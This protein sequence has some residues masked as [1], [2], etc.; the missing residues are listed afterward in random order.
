MPVCHLSQICAIC[1]PYP[2][3]V[4]SGFQ[5]RRSTISSSSSIHPDQSH[6]VLANDP[7]GYPA[8]GQPYAYDHPVSPDPTGYQP[9][10]AQPVQPAMYN[11]PYEST[12]RPSS[13]HP[14]YARQARR[15]LPP[16]SSG[17]APVPASSGF[18]PIAQQNTGYYPP[19]S[20]TPAPVHHAPPPTPGLGSHPS[21]YITR[22]PPVNP[23]PTPA[24]SNFSFASQ[25]YPAPSGFTP[26]SAY[27]HIP[28]P[29]P[30][31]GYQYP[32]PVPQQHLQY[33]PPQLPP[34]NTN[35]HHHPLPHPPTP[36]SVP[37]PTQTANHNA[38]YDHSVY[39]NVPPPPP[40][41]P[42]TQSPAKPH[43]SRPLPVPGQPQVRRR[44]STIGMQ[45]QQFVATQITGAQPGANYGAYSHV[46]PPPPIPSSFST[47]SVHSQIRQPP[48]PPPVSGSALP[49]APS[50]QQLPQVPGPPPL[51]PPRTPSRAQPQALQ[52]P[53]YQTPPSRRQSFTHTGPV[54]AHQ[55]GQNPPPSLQPR[56]QPVPPPP[57]PHTT[58]G[59]GAGPTSH[60]MALAQSG[61]HASPH[62]S[63]TQ[64]PYPGPLP[65]P[66]Q[67]PSS[68]S[69]HGYP[70]TNGGWQ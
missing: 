10:P 61:F 8:Q 12:S 24:P 5:S 36:P 44:H 39:A 43:A 21:L 4:S 13:V 3:S 68:Q 37:P 32:E 33:A 18:G 54:Y 57:P 30:P 35:G 67:V 41:T 14:G 46:P 2:Q 58:Y 38:G 7:Y 11:P 64:A 49:Y 66:P 19:V 27:Q 53:P 25:Q 17:F 62:S 15:S 47:S 59:A 48:P 1:S 51:P 40:I 60:T 26:P 34:P 56:Y 52:L 22:P 28:Q 20:A 9:F 45:E 63:S 65:V 55:T 29:Q 6:S 70:V 50:Q 42:T 69:H 16:A 31:Y 23:A